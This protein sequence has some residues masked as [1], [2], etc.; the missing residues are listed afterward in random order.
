[1]LIAAFGLPP[2]AHEDDSTRAVEAAL[3]IYKL[4][5]SLKVMHIFAFN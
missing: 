3:D 2:L 1:M 5:V 4:L